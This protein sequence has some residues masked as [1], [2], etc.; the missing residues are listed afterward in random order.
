MADHSHAM[1][2]GVSRLWRSPRSVDLL[3][4]GESKW[5]TKLAPNIM[6]TLDGGGARFFPGS[7]AGLWTTASLHQRVPKDYFPWVGQRV[8]L[9]GPL[10]RTCVLSARSTVVRRR[11]DTCREVTLSWVREKLAEG[12]GGN[13]Y[14]LGVPCV[15]PFH[16][17][18]SRSCP[19]DTIAA[20]SAEQKT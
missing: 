17:M 11:V 6:A 8:R 18:P 13:G 3:H 5:W 2:G 16:S 4:Q 9:P 14:Q 19:R 12:D 1:Q 15:Q 20:K 10:L 7:M